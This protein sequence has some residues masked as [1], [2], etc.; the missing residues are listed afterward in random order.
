[1]ESRVEMPRAS[2][3]LD[4][5]SGE[6]RVVDLDQDSGLDLDGD[7]LTFREVLD[8]WDVQEVHVVSEWALM[9]AVWAL[10]QIQA[11][12]DPTTTAR[13]ALNEI[14]MGSDLDD[15]TEFID[16]ADALFTVRPIERVAGLIEPGPARYE[17]I[18]PSNQKVR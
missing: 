16:E 2:V 5:E 17:W 14:A 7:R 8:G 15:H 9:V 10:Q 3:F 4:N 11:G 13:A 6:P 18:A 12:A 1:M